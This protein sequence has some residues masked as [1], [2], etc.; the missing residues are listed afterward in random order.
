MADALIALLLTSL[1]LSGLLSVN[2]TTLRTAVSGETRLTAALIARAVIED[3]SMREDAGKVEV[4]GRTY[5]W[6]RDRQD[7]PPDMK[8]RALLTTISVAV[9][10]QG[11]SGDLVY[12]LETA[13]VKGR[14]H[15]G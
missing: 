6:Q 12:R 10:W 9:H 7:L 14:A 1:F 8:D 2:A 4:A 15:E 11:R 13:R 3:P 5:T